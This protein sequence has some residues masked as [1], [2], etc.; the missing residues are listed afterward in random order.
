MLSGSTSFTG[1]SGTFDRL[2]AGRT[3][4]AAER[5]GVAPAESAGAATSRV[6]GAQ[7]SRPIEETGKPG[8]AKNAGSEELTEGE[9]KQ[10]Q[11]LKKRDAEVRAHEQAHAAA[12]GMY[13]G[14]P[15]YEF[16]TGPDGR[17]YAISGE[18]EIDVAPVRDN[19]EATIR[20]MDVVIRAALA[21]AEPSSQDMAVARTAQQQRAQAQS[22]LTKQRAEEQ[23]GGGDENPGEAGARDE[24]ERLVAENAYRST[25]SNADIASQIFSASLVA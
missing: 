16:T 3:D 6:E 11:E 9:E 2:S 1:S 10:V 20:K 17:K 4:Q 15:K 5:I 21:P 24:A 8:K 25:P 22:E 14:P 13:A 12:G 23:N 18:V 19:P 7:S